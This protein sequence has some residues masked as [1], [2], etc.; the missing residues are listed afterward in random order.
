[1]ACASKGKTIVLPHTVNFSSGKESMCQTGFR[2][3]SWGEATHGYAMSAQLLTTIKFDMLIE[4]AQHFM[5]LI[6]SCNKTTDPEVIE[7]DN[8][9]DE[10]AHLIDNLDNSDYKCI[11]FILSL[12]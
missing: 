5:K 3:V 11:Y 12:P 2:D 9:D 7:I 6:H 4:E 10:C 1:M 8:D